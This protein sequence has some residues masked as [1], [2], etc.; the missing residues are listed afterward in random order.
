MP[1][2]SKRIAEMKSFVCGVCRKPIGQTTWIL[3]FKKHNI[4]G[5]PQV[6]RLHEECWDGSGEEA[7]SG[8]ATDKRER[9]EEEKENK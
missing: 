5:I 4:K 9:E 2:V 7:R 1:P 3:G 8:N 6:F